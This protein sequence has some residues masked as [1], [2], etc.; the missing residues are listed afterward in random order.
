LPHYNTN[1]TA[2]RHRHLEKLAEIDR[3]IWRTAAV[4]VI[5]EILHDANAMLGIE[6]H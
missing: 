6:P 2:P 4:R 1:E 3:N 5:D